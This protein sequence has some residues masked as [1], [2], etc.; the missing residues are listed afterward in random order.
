MRHHF[1][2]Y[3]SV[4]RL[5]VLV[6]GL[7]TL[8]PFTH[9]Q[10]D[11]KSNILFILDGSGSMLGQIGKTSKMAIAKEVMTTLIRQLPDS[12]KVGLAVYGHRSKGD[13]NDIEVMS[14]V[15]KSDKAMLVKQIQSIQPK[16]KTPITS[17]LKLAAEQ[18]KASEE[19]TT[20]VLISDGEE[21]CDGDPCAL[22]KELIAH[23]IKV[24]VHV[25][26]F[27][28]NP[29]E[30]EQLMCIAEAGQGKY[31]TAQTTSQLKDALTQVKEEVIRTGEATPK[32]PATTTSQKVVKITRPAVGTIE[33]KNHVSGM[34]N[35]LDQQ[36]DEQRAQFCNGCGSNTQVPAGTYK[37]RF[38]NFFVEGVEV[39]AGEKKV[40]DAN[41]VAGTI[42]I[43]N[44]VSGMVNILDQQTDEQ[45]AQFC[46]GCGSNTQVPAGTYK[47]RFPNFT[48][49]DVVVEAGQN[50]VIK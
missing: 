35:I 13:C 48:V 44:H 1:Q 32:E 3:L 36:T 26:G 15:G 16:G 40:F 31:F 41:T 21:T 33:I 37:L 7:L 23:G 5:L 39:G 14:P 19:D 34:V 24:R 17:A 28:V 4:I 11:S 46:N 6:L 8:Q 22:V 45:R 12:V 43:K 2:R 38:P 47:L 30:R 29:R 25:V 10:S 27:D 49:D 50:V 42:E 18:L 20:V 9:A